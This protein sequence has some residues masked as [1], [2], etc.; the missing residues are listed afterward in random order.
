MTDQNQTTSNTEGGFCS[1]VKIPSYSTLSP[2]VKKRIEENR[3]KAKAIQLERRLQNGSNRT[4][5]STEQQNTNSSIEQQNT[6]SSIEQQNINSSTEQQN[7]NSSTEQQ[8]ANSSTNTNANNQEE[9]LRPMKKF[10]NYVDY[11]LSKMINTRGGFLFET[12]DENSKKRKI[13]ELEPEDPPIDP[14]H[15]DTPRCKECKTVEID[16]QF[17]RIFR[18]NIC[19]S[20]KE[21]FPEKYSLLTKT[22]AKE[23]YLLTD[24]ELKDE[25]RLPHLSKPNPHKSTWNDMM[26]YLR[27]QVEEF[28]FEKWGGAD[29][30][31]K[32]FERRQDEKKKRKDKKFKSKLADLRKRTRT[33]ELEKN[34]YKEHKHEF[35][36]AV[37]DPETGISTQTCSS[38]GISFE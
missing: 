37:E 38:C 31:D 22:E 27:E 7:T 10:Q 9:K 6:N 29:A 36:M 11:D 19:K 14:N 4:F 21:K 3:L 12:P 30:L 20:C 23:D 2:E 17:H 32:E 33:D 16:Y 13:R 5:Q 24:A 8:N 28:S 15:P 25:E 35:G 1:E 26:L 18:V 34:R